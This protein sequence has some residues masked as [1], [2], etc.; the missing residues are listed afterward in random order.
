MTRLRRIMGT[1]FLW[2]MP[3]RVRRAGIA[4]TL[5]R[6]TRPSSDPWPDR[7][8]DSGYQTLSSP[9]DPWISKV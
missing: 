5:R 3:Q 6:M 1:A 7:F 9:G 8:R 4:R 2:V